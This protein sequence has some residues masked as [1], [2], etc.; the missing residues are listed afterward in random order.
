MKAFAGCR[1][2]CALALF[3]AA[4]WIGMPPCRADLI[5]SAPAPSPV[6]EEVARAS[7]QGNLE[8]FG[9]TA[10]EARER[11][12]ALEENDLAVL[13]EN[14]AQVQVAGGGVTIGLMLLAAGV[15][16]FLVLWL[17]GTEKIKL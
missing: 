16:I 8:A 1:F 13:A 17:I 5:A 2:A 14:P 12:A 6:G 4:L 11:L 9:L 7:V 3:A 15:V 10:D